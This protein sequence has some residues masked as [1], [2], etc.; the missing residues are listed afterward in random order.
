MYIWKKTVLYVVKVF[1]F[2]RCIF[3]GKFGCAAT[4]GE[5]VSV[6]LTLL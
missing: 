3:G 1:I 5:E 2:G 6:S 4:S